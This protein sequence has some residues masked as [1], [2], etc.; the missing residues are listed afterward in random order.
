MS[1]S[2]SYIIRQEKEIKN[3]FNTERKKQH[4]LPVDDVCIENLCWNDKWI[5]YYSN[6]NNIQ[7]PVTFWYSN[8]KIIRKRN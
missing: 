4:Y 6:T 8:D 3:F 1:G 5:K 7:K 2:P